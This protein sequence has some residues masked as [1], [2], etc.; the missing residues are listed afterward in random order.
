LLIAGCSN[1]KHEDQKVST[2][3][4]SMDAFYVSDVFL[5]APEVNVEQQIQKLSNEYTWKSE[6]DVFRNSFTCSYHH[7]SGGESDG[8]K[9]I[10]EYLGNWRGQN[11]IARYYWTGGSGSFSDIMFC[12]LR[13]GKLPSA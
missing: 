12:S 8:G 5:D 2:I 4:Q 10:C 1:V 6:T 7:K 11:I 9:I 13:D 3:A